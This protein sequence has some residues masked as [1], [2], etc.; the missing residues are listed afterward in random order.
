MT[1]QDILAA[2]ERLAGVALHTPLVYSQTLSRMSG[3]E[4]FL[5]LENLQTTGS[6]KLRG[7]FNRLALLQGRGEGTRVVAASAG[8]HG[9]GV[10]H[11]AGRLG[12]EAV[13]VMPRGAS[14]SKQMACASYGA[15][16]RLHGEDLSQ[17]LEEARVLEQQGYVFI[18]PYDDPEVVAGQGTLGLEILDDLPRVATVLLPVGGGGLA[19]GT[20][21]AL[22]ET[23][24]DVRVVGVQAARVPSLVAALE[25]GEPQRVEA[26]STLADGIRVPVVGRHPFPF[27][28][29]CLDEVALVEEVDIARAVLILLEKKKVLAEGAGAAPTAAL[30]GPLA[31]R[32]LG[33]PVVLVVSGGNM[34][35]PLLERVLVRALSDRRR[36]LNLRVALPDRPGS[37]GRLATL[38]G[39]AQA[40]I[41]H[42][43]HDRMGRDLPL[44][45]TRVELILET[46]DQEHGDRVIETLRA[47]GYQV[48]DRT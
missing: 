14:I 1:L 37:L 42:L 32:G 34:D 21:F 45:I 5:K 2:R 47:A 25:R 10:A 27:L 36:L 8:N 6:F 15:Q 19:A 44:E 24:P 13:I 48:E 26:R 20:A 7:A 11:A 28:Q 29:R 35:I 4:V 9:Q 30:L 33:D 12:L 16:V 22:K 23:K 41:L 40:N 17:A 18:H 46:R 39:E 43:F 31:G 38:L 3:R